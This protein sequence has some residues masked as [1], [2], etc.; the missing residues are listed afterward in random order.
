MSGNVIQFLVGPD[1]VAFFIHDNVLS[2]ACDEYYQTLREAEGADKLT[3]L[4]DVDLGSFERFSE[5]LYTGGISHVRQTTA[6]LQEAYVRLY[7]S[8]VRITSDPLTRA[9]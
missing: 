4:P 1:E 7:N 8:P 9:S 6:S 2:E 3:R 5:W